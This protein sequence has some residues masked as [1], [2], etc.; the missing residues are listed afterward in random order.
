MAE[1]GQ[2]SQQ[3]AAE[4]DRHYGRRGVETVDGPLPGSTDVAM[5]R[6]EEQLHVATTTRA[7]ERVRLRKYVVTEERTI[8]VSI[9][10]EELRLEREPI[11]D[12][13]SEPE[14][15]APSLRVDAPAEQY[16]MVLHE[17]QVFVEKRVVPVER[18]TLTKEVVTEQKQITE[19][20]RREQIETDLDGD[21]DPAR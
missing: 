20:V 2:L 11:T 8:T 14:A 10:R 13:G 19:Q 5:I 7:S 3:E 12:V 6:S 18:V 4:L 16:E 1:N 9:R 21:A 15:A 17:E